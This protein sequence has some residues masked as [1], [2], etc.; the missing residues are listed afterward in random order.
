MTELG[1]PR[2]LAVIFAADMVRCSLLME[3]NERE[4]IARETPG[5]FRHNA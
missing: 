3:A 5:G 2:R 1:E 4:T